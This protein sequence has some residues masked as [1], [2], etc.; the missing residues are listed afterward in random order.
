M[1]TGLLRAA[2]RAP[3]NV[4]LIV[5]DDLAAC[6]GSYGN[7]VCKTPNLDRLA[8]EGVVFE[9]A[10]CQYPVCGPSRASFMSGLY[11][12]T[13]KMLGNRKEAGAFKSTNRALAEHPSI[14]EFLRKNG[15]FSGRVGKI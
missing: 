13:T 12:N 14:G 1:S 9:R 6:L 8:R 5:A 10:Y 7:T 2:E 3:M 11:P 15:Y 4:L